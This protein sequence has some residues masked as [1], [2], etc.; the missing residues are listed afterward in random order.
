M[1]THKESEAALKKDA[2]PKIGN[3]NGIYWRVCVCTK[4]GNS[5]QFL[6]LAA[7]DPF[8]PKSPLVR[9]SNPGGQCVLK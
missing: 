5:E 6:K 8:G 2:Q 3:F 7:K 1:L 4:L 9:F